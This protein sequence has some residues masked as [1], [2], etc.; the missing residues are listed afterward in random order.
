[1]NQEEKCNVKYDDITKMHAY[2]D[3]IKLAKGAFVLYP[4][5]ESIVY[6]E[7]EEMKY[8]GVVA[9]SLKSK[10]PDDIEK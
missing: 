1:M 4:G 5:T 3:A 7:N 8:V 10:R 2:K 6:S 9:F